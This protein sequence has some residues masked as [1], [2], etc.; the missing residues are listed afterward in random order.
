M[1]THVQIQ[2]F[3]RLNDFVAVDKRHQA[4]DFAFI[5]P[6]SIKD[7]IESIGV[8][9]TEVD[10]VLVDDKSVDFHYLVTGGER[11]KVYPHASRLALPGLIHNLPSNPSPPRFVL[12]VHLGRLAGY[13]RMLG[14][15]T[16][17]RNDYDDPTLAQISQL[18]QRILVTS[19]R[20]LLMRKQVS[21]GYLM[22]SHNPRRQIKE[23]MNRYQLHRHS[24]QLVRC[25]DC[26]GIIRAV[27][28]QEIVA[29]LLPLTRKYYQSFYQCED[30]KKI[31]WKGSHYQ[32]MQALIS[33][34][35]A[36]A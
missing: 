27:D 30:C 14:F 3:T 4:F 23:L 22:R 16:L 35:M 33:S 9:H 21:L 32:R 28:K 17:Y 26:N 31:F 5:K 20:R 19:D 12:D 25:R 24:T 15:D 6:R 1:T 8:P 2:F 10:I 29:Q 18:E 7:L 13:L 11:I 34:I 36:D